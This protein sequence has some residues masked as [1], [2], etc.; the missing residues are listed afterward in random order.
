VIPRAQLQVGSREWAERTL[1]WVKSLWQNHQTT[2][3]H[4]LAAVA[5][6]QSGRAWEALGKADLNE[7]LQSAIG[8]T[9]EQSSAEM[10]YR[11]RGRPNQDDKKGYNITFSDSSRGTHRKYILAR[12]QRDKKYDLLKQIHR[13]VISANQAAIEARYRKPPKTP[14]EQLQHWWT[15][16]SIKERAK[17]RREISE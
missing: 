4:W 6:L 10:E 13:G 14:L 11:F 12:L 17:F 1:D 9:L 3:A 2:H 8:V 5:E 15:R 16:A 7:L